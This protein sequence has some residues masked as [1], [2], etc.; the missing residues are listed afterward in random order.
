MLEF[1]TEATGLEIFFG[2]FLI[3]R[4]NVIKRIRGY[5]DFQFLS[6]PIFVIY[7]FQN[8]CLF[9]LGFSIFLL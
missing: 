3:F 9:H 4:F 6:M 7:A 1:T 8:I 2:E 5:S